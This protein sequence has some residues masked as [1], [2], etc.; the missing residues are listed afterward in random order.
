MNII[1]KQ[2][3]IFIGIFCLLIGFMAGY[4]KGIKDSNTIPVPTPSES[5]WDP[6]AE[7]TYEAGHKE[8]EASMVYDKDGNLDIAAS[9]KNLKALAEKNIKEIEKE[10]AKHGCNESSIKAKEAFK[11]AIKTVNE[12][13]K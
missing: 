8:L 1:D 3:V 9:S 10:E 7:A 4:N 2:N 13:N 11:E 5:D 12:V 6:V